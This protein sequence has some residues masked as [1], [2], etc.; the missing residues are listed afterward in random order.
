MVVLP[1]DV[2]ISGWDSSLERTGTS[3]RPAVRLGLSLV[4]GMR[5]GV[6]RRIELA[7]AVRAFESVS[8]LARRA[9]LD[10]RDLKVLA[11]A[12][13]LSSLAG[14]RREASWHAVAAV[15]D[16]DML[17]TAAIEEVTP[18]LGTPSE[19][20]GIVADYRSTGLTLG[21][22]PLELLR[23]RLAKQR[24]MP[25][26]VLHMYRNGQL[27]RGCGIVT[28]RQQPSTANG[29]IFVTME[30]ETGNVNV[31]IRPDVLRA[32][33]REV[34]G[35]SLLGVYGVWQREGEVRHLVAQR[36]VDLSSLL[37]GLMTRSRDF[38]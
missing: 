31:I 8:D 35:A 27:A 24:L 3:P 25:A 6:A 2:T 9:E 37:G 21:R 18:A 23:P 12:N 20:D 28:V 14:N 13:A 11:D 30:D 17:S 34:L 15:P 5:D 26:R 4:S 16:R 19:A 33:R 29:V 36:L 7:R 32:Q 22:H 38:S 1:A 10:R